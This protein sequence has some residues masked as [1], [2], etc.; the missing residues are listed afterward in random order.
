MIEALH[1]KR[2]FG[3]SLYTAI[4]RYE[5]CMAEKGKISIG[6]DA[7]QNADEGTISRFEEIISEYVVAISEI[8]VYAQHPLIRYGGC[9]YS[10]EMRDSFK[11]GLD[12]LGEGIRQ[13][14]RGT[15]LIAPAVGLTEISP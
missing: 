7:L 2:N 10:T 11:N 3:E 1:E 9:E 4:E 14:R 5:Q 15:D 12:R 8:G 13:G 6:R